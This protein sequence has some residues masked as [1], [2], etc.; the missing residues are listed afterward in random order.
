MSGWLW[1]FKTKL[2]T[3]AWEGREVRGVHEI[4]PDGVFEPATPFWHCH[5][6]HR[7]QPPRPRPT[8]HIPVLEMLWNPWQSRLPALPALLARLWLLFV[9]PVDPPYK[10]PCGELVP[11]MQRRSSLSQCSASAGVPLQPSRAWQ[12]PHRGYIASLLNL[13]AIQV[14]RGDAPPALLQGKMSVRVCILFR[15]QNCERK[16]Q[17]CRKD[18]L[19]KSRRFILC[20]CFGLL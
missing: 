11:D 6:K 16:S 19:H 7:A 4:G 2:Q 17:I 20:L 13:W 18:S 10:E 12:S 3:S 9:N 15:G 5:L 14:E 1:R 8:E